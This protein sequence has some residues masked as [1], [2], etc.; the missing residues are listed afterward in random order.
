SAS[1]LFVA[2][3][4]ADAAGKRTTVALERIDLSVSPPV[5]VLLDDRD[6]VPRS[7]RGIGRLWDGRLLLAGGRDPGG[8]PTVDTAVFDPVTGLVEKSADLPAP[9]AGLAGTVAMADGTVF[10]STGEQGT[11]GAFIYVAPVAPLLAATRV[12]LAIN[13]LLATRAS[14]SVTQGGV[15]Y[16]T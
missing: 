8:A 9:Q 11:A 10:H 13:P 4:A 7:A 14:G 5:S 12:A 1:E 3:G 16:R 6:A 15:S 2:G